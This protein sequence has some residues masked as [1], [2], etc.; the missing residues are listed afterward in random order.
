MTT[1]EISQL[2]SYQYISKLLLIV[3]GRAFYRMID[4]TMMSTLS[5][6]WYFTGNN[7]L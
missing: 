7:L 5:I 3:I 2:G 4:S 6:L 1:F